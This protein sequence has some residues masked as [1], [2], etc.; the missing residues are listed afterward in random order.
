[1]AR[2]PQNKWQ[3]S[4]AVHKIDRDSVTLI[5]RLLKFAPVMKERLSFIDV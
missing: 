2:T 3:N 5:S 1:M 4:R